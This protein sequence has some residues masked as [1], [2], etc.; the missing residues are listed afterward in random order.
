MNFLHPPTRPNIDEIGSAGIEIRA[1]VSSQKKAN[2]KKN[3]VGTFP[4]FFG[5][6]KESKHINPDNPGFLRIFVVRGCLKYVAE[7]HC[8]RPV[9]PA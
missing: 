9:F 7:N 4:C 5:G 3:G 1:S 2:V 8:K 6:A